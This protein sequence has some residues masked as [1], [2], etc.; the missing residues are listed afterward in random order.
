MLVT[1]LTPHIGYEKSAKIAQTAH[2]ERTSLREAALKLGHVSE[3]EFDAWVRARGHDAPE[4]RLT[5]SGGL[6]R[7]PCIRPAAA[8]AACR[9]FG[10]A[11]PNHD[12]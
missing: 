2:R 4:R 9:T 8:R 11:R 10:G 3:A 1:A 5:R 12:T 7:T 6:G